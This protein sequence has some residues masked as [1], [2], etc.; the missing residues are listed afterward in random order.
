MAPHLQ[1][2]CFNQCARHRF[3]ILPLTGMQM[4][5]PARAT[6][7]SLVG[8]L[9]LPTCGP[10]LVTLELGDKRRPMGFGAPLYGKNLTHAEAYVRIG[11][12]QC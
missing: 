4:G 2:V 7:G 8:W 6:L 11:I 10:K 3:V 5:N 12:V 9:K 1:V